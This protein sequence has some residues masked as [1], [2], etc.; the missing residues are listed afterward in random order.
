[1]LKF[2]TVFKNYYA[3]NVSPESILFPLV[4]DL[5][6]QEEIPLLPECSRAPLCPPHQNQMQKGKEILLFVWLCLALA[7]YFCLHCL[8]K[9][10]EAKRQRKQ[11]R[12][13]VDLGTYQGPDDL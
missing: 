10:I 3:S 1:M 5:C 12:L 4:W 2:P 8:R 7:N 11:E 9:E 13:N 6:F